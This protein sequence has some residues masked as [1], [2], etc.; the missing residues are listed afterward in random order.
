MQHRKIGMGGMV[1]LIGKCNSKP[2]I[3]VR[4]KIIMPFKNKVSRFLIF[5]VHFLLGDGA[6][7]IENFYNKNTVMM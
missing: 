1:P 5:K 3:S 2:D 7:I 4:Q 6:V